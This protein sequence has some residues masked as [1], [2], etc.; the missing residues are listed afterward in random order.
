MDLSGVARIDAGGI[1]ELVRAHNIARAI[2][3]SV[4]IAHTTEHIREMLARVGLFD[5][6]SADD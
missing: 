2:N 5:L 6:L 4:R 3:V 1:G